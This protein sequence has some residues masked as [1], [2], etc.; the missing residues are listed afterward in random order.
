M[1]NIVYM[2][3]PEIAVNCLEKLFEKKDINIA[4]VVTQ[5]DRPCGRGKKLTSPPIKVAAQKLDIPVY[6]TE[7]IK[8][9]EE[10]KST[11]K[12]LKPDFFVTFAFGQ[13]LTQEV[14]DIP[15][16]ATINLH[17]S[18]LPKYR[19]ANP[20]Q[21][22]IYNGD[23]ETGITTMITVLALD[24][25]DIC[26]QEKIE[27]SE[28]MTDEEL[29]AS[30]SAKSPD[31]MYSTLTGLADGSLTPQKQ[32]DAAMTIA[33]KF[34]KEDSLINWGLTAQEIHDHVRSMTT[35]PVASTTFNGKVLKILK[36]QVVDNIKENADCG[37][38][39]EITKEGIVVAA[40]KG[41]VLLKEL[42][43]EGKSKM[44]AYAWTNGIKLACGEKFV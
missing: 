27:I 41:A 36:T 7:S 15:N 44:D 26:K 29:F 6:Q 31:L 13:I 25:G 4:A 10:L 23:K 19:G 33:K 14:L 5:P 24:A 17:A 38:V 9:D 35:W 43:P 1:I 18:L 8:N 22:A 34:K 40:A 16:I 42:K 39:I 20:I 37:K 28:S 3:T 21:R 11:L 30:I 12:N 2:G 32:D